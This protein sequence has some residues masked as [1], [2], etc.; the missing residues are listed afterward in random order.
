M[1]FKIIISLLL[2][3]V[4]ISACNNTSDCDSKKEQTSK[5]DCYFED[6]K[7]TKNVELCNNI[8]TEQIKSL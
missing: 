5:D 2:L 4:L 3:L 7:T 6:A 8:Q 1:K